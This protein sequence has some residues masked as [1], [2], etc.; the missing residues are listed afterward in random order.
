[1]LGIIEGI[2]WEIMWEVYL[3]HYTATLIFSLYFDF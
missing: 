3:G 2:Y 1:M